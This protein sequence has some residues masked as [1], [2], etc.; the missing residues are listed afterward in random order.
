M[1]NYIVYDKDFTTECP[2]REISDME[3]LRRI[4]DSKQYNNYIDIYAD[5]ILDD[6]GEFN[7]SLAI[8]D[9]I[10]Y[11]KAIESAKTFSGFKCN[12]ATLYIIPDNFNCNSLIRV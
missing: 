6:N 1:K 9:D 4:F 5:I 7:S 12:N 11:R 8:I 10:F 3:V 2:I